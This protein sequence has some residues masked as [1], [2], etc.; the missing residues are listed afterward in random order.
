MMA[1]VPLRFI[2]RV[3]HWS[4]RWAVAIDSSRRF[5]NRLKVQWLLG[6]IFE[7]RHQGRKA[8][9]ARVKMA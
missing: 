6:N 7:A 1:G 2:P 9:A 5:S 4:A 8:A 3:I